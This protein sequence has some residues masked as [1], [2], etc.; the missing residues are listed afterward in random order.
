MRVPQRLGKYPISRVI[1]E[2]AMGVVYEAF[3]PVI[4]RPLAIKTIRRELVEGSEKGASMV[5]RFRNEAQA[6][7]RLMH[8]GIAAVH[9]Y[10]ED[11]DCA[12]IVREFVSGASLREY[13]AR[14]TRFPEHD[15]LS[16]M[17]QLLDALEYA[18][19]RGVWHR[20]IKPANLMVTRTGQLKITDFGIARIEANGLT[21]DGALI[22]T[23]GYMAPEQFGSEPIDHR[24]DV[25]AAGALLYQLLAGRLPFTGSLESVMFRT[26]TETPPPPS[27]VAGAQQWAH[28]DEV[29]LRAMATDRDRR[30]QDAARFRQALVELN[31]RPVAPT[32]AEETVIVD[33]VRPERAG[34]PRTAPS[35]GAPGHASTRPGETRGTAS[36]VPS[37]WDAQT[38]ARVESRLTVHLGP[39]AKVLVRRAAAQ[40][41]DVQT[42]CERLAEH[43]P[44][45]GERADFLQSTLTGAGGPSRDLAADAHASATR[46]GTRVTDGAAAP[47]PQAVLDHAERVLATHIGPIAKV[48]VKK[49]AAQAR[50]RQGLHQGIVALAGASA[51]PTLASD[52]AA[53]PR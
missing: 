45:A 3:D 24:V 53:G 4:R 5:A 43:L 18:H 20:D 7:G 11:D 52:L 31:A 14:N 40:C 29:V 34:G 30:F 13:L 36:L 44:H 2:G 46:T 50:D 38:L 47:L 16:I 51:G 22:G 10:G 15:V 17:C 8:P 32:L 23:P 37:G 39:V 28:F 26:A 49:A 48:I 35:G 9:E 19:E 12:Y 41:T 25:Y 1:G 6:A 42:L 33:P 27:S 21:L